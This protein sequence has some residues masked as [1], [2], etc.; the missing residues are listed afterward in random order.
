[1]FCFFCKITFLQITILY[2]ICS[3]RSE[4]IENVGILINAQGIKKEICKNNMSIFSAI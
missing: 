3:M 1:M 2:N 4:I